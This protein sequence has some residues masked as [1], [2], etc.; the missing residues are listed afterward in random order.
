[1]PQATLDDWAKRLPDICSG[2]ALKDVFNTDETGLY[3]RS[4]PKISMVHKNDERKGIKTSKERM[5]VLL[6]CSA[7]GEKLKPLIIGKSENPR[8]FKNVHKSILGVDYEWNR[9]S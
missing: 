6:A 4:L 1:M 3:Y 8:C 2:Y 9:K 7:T 5:T